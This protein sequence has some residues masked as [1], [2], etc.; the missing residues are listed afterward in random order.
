[1][2]LPCGCP[3]HYPEEWNGQ[4][5][6]LGGWLVHDHP[7]PMLLHFPIAFD[8]Y[9]KQQVEDIARLGLTER[10]PGFVLTRSAAFRGRHLR[11]LEE[12]DCAARRVHYLPSPFHL[13]VAMHR[14]D[15]GSVR[16]VIQQMQTALIDAGLMPK[17][18][19]LAY[20]TCP[21]C[22]ADRGGNRMMV[23]RRWVPSPKLRERLERQQKQP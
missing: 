4:D 13:R 1:M 18:V 9:R 2:T 6:D 19:Y 23:L 3:Q 15:V 22:A 21:L 20:L 12:E 8:L 5:V 11:L 17:E 16:P 14:G 10:W 7:A